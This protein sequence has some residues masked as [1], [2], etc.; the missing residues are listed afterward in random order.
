M[1]AAFSRITMTAASAM[2]L[3][4]LVVLWRRHAGAYITA[5]RTQSITLAVTGA[6]VA[7]YGTAPEL[8]FVSFMILVVKGWIVPSVLSAMDAKRRS[9]R[10]LH[11]LLNTETS[12]LVCGALA[13]AMT[14]D[15]AVTGSCEVAESQTPVLGVAVPYAIANVLLT[16]LGPI[17][18]GLT[19]AV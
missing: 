9:G 8:F 3:L 13:G 11:P 5:F 2:L 7:F 16:V 14:V 12:L 4:S 19:L 6:I 1:E 18:V 17:I 15:A 10:E